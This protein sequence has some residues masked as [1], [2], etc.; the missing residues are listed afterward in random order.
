M[1]RT[2]KSTSKAKAA[3]EEPK[4]EQTT[5]ETKAKDGATAM[6]LPEEPTEPKPEAPEQ[7]AEAPEQPA[8]EPKPGKG[9]GKPEG[10]ADESATT[11][12]AKAAADA[13]VAPDADDAPLNDNTAEMR[14]ADE[15]ED[16]KGAGTVA[17]EEK[18]RN[19]KIEAQADRDEPGTN[20]VAPSPYEETEGTVAGR[21]DHIETARAQAEQ[22]PGRHEGKQG[23]YAHDS[24]DLPVG[25]APTDERLRRNAPSDLPIA[26]GGELSPAEP[27][28]EAEGFKGAAALNPVDRLRVPGAPLEPPAG[29]AAAPSP[30]EGG[31]DKVSNPGELGAALIRENRPGSR[32]LDATTGEAPDPESLFEPESSVGTSLR[33]KVRLVQHTWQGPHGRPLRQLVMT[34]GQVV[35]PEKAKQVVSILKAQLAYEE[36]EKAAQE[37]TESESN[38]GDDSGK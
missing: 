29:P 36:Q 13:E 4:V 23:V 7:P 34:K 11:E 35:G 2:S 25:S 10:E 5:D 33:C 17:P 18:A 16:F 6:G 3:A 32:L 9:N 38:Q 27:K 15:P 12:E 20:E 24:K 1:A 22:V 19:E 26:D 30:S 31:E 14:V 37:S 28:N 8:E 21:H